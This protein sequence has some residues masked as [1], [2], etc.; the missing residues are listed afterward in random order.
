MSEFLAR[1]WRMTAAA[2]QQSNVPWIDFP[3]ACALSG[4][5]LTI[6]GYFAIFLAH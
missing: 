2:E 1:R 5:L 6:V 4:I 3:V